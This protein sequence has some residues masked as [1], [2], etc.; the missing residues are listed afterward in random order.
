MQAAAAQARN[1]AQEN[2]RLKRR[3]G[4][5]EGAASRLAEYENRLATLTK[6]IERLN[7]VLKAK[8]DEAA[9]L[10]RAANDL[11]EE[12]RQLKTRLEQVSVW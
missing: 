6:E 8:V 9:G 7:V 12:N 10:H 11:A 1:L 5:L 2:E 4:E 3:I